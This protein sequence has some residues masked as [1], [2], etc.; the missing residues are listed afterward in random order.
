MARDL[1]GSDWPFGLLDRHVD[2]QHRA[3]RCVPHPRGGYKAT[4]LGVVRTR[5]PRRTWALDPRWIDRFVRK[6]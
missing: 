6:L 5:T 3:S 1:G 2:A 4:A